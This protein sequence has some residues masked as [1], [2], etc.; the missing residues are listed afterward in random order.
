[1]KTFSKTLALV[2]LISSAAS[3]K[4][5]G[6]FSNAWASISAAPGRAWNYTTGTANN[7]YHAF[8]GEDE[9][10]NADGTHKGY[11]PKEPGY[12]NKVLNRH[13][14]GTV[15]VV[16]TVGT[17][18]YLYRSKS[19]QAKLKSWLNKIRGQKSVS[20]SEENAV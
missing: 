5:E 3:V 17:G 1:M 20:V 14:L 12:V 18:I 16:A 13:V 2:V 9:E 15:A 4:A 8:R 19:A 10:L 7:T 11:I 6:F